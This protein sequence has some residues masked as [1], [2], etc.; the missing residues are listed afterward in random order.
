M[1]V[2]FQKFRLPTE[3]VRGKKHER[4]HQAGLCLLKEV[5]FR[6]YQLCG[7]NMESELSAD[8]QG[9]PF[10]TNY[11]QVYF[12]ISHGKDLVV[13]GV[14]HAPL[15]VDVEA[16]RPVKP[17]VFRR[18]LTKKELHYL[19]MSR[20]RE[21]ENA[22]YRE[23]FRLWTLKESYA[24][25]VGKGLALDFTCLE[26]A[27]ETWEEEPGEDFFAQKYESKLSYLPLWQV[28]DLPCRGKNERLFLLREVRGSLDGKNELW[29]FFQTIIEGEYVISCCLSRRGSCGEEKGAGIL[30]LLG[31][32]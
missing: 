27:L 18:V 11:P 4:E 21:G 28:Q 22:W 26:F 20:E 30:G 29:R 8:S 14:D 17:T 6:E 7:M 16:I 2:Y 25:A 5:L 15:G 31:V 13:C 3:G 12:N 1:A 10:L 32:L 9:K 24:K 19:E 23:F